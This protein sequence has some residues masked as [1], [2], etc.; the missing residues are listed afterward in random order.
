MLVEKLKKLMEKKGEEIAPE[1][2]AAKR[3]AVQEMQDI[4]KS[5]MKGGLDGLQKVTVASPTKEGLKKG[6]D[7][8][9]EVIESAPSD[10]G[11]GASAEPMHEEE[12]EEEALESPMEKKSEMEHPEME[13]IE[14]LLGK[15]PPEKLKEMLLKA[16]KG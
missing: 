14:S 4:A 7:K 6:L 5:A 15:L 2:L 10:K 9:E 8:A 1:K 3:S 11:P 12:E 16:I 13:D